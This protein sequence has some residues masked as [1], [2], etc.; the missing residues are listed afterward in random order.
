MLGWRIARHGMAMLATVLVGGLLSAT[1]VRIAPGFDSDERQLDPHLSSE[2]V[3]A[4][5]AERARDHNVVRFYA[6]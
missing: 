5:R 6:Q 1:L 4:L 3:Q 2:S